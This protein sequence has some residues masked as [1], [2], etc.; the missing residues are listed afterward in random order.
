MWVWVMV[1]RVMVCIVTIL[2]LLIL[3]FGTLN[4]EVPPQTLGREAVC[5]R[6]T[7]TVYPP[8]LIIKRT[9]SP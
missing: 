3:I 5:L 9:G 4:I 8:P 6:V 7:L 2:T 1:L